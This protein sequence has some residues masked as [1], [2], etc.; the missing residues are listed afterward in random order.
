LATQ[1][2]EMRVYP[3]LQLVQAEDATTHVAIAQKVP[4]PPAAGVI[5][6]AV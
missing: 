5:D 6:V 2:P 1:A 4:Y 3:L